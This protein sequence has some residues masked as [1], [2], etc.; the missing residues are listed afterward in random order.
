MEFNECIKESQ[1]PSDSETE[2][3]QLVPEFTTDSD[4]QTTQPVEQTGAEE[5]SGQ[6]QAHLQEGQPV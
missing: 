2:D 4:D 5:Q 3:Y 6:V 1:I